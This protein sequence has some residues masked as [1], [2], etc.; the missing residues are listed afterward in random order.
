MLLIFVISSMEVHVPA[1][2]H[3]PLRDKGIHF[4]EYAILGW[5]C[6]GA[7]AR[8]WHTSRARRTATFAVFVAA[9]W[10]ISDEIHQSFVPGRSA[11]VADAI[12]D[13]AGAVAGVGAWHLLSDRSVS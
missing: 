2:R 11:E 5:F 1:V 4:I 9:A 6:A 13:M 8:T 7:A 10:G 12:A 3:F